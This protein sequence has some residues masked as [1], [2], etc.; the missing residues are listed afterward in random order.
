MEIIT[1]DEYQQA[2][3]K[4]AVYPQDNLERAL[5]YTALG[6]TGEAGEVANQ[7]KKIIRDDDGTIT[8]DRRDKLID[9]LGDV[10]WY[11][12]AMCYE[13]SIH[14]SSVAEYNVEKLQKRAEADTLHG[15]VRETT[16]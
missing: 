13:L 5:A 14:M 9:E 12:S 10:L 15:D 16:V 7:V 4:T 6:L 3:R 2:A 8:V 1:F 11:V